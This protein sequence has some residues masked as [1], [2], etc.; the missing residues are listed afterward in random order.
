MT[1]YEVSLNPLP[2]QA[3]SFIQG[4]YEYSIRLKTA[5]DRL[6][7]DLTVNGDIIFEGLRCDAGADMLSSFK[8]LGFPGSLF[9]LTKDDEPPYWERLGSEDK[10]YYAL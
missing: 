2:A 7:M 3:F 6:Y 8:Y 10:L 5:G 9:F 1:L 4:D